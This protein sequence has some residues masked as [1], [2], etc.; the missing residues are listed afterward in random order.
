[1]SN[2]LNNLFVTANQEVATSSHSL[3]G[4]AQ[5]TN[6]ASGIAQQIMETVN[7]NIEEYTEDIS[8]SKVD[9]NAMDNLIEKAYELHDVDI[10]FLK[11]I[12]E[13]TLEGMLKSQQSKR[14]RCKSKAMTLDNYKALMT[15]AIAENLIRIATGKEK[16]AGIGRRV[17]GAVEYTIEQLEALEADQEKLRKEIRNI[18]SKK[19]IMKSKADFDENDERYQSLLKVEQQLKDMRVG[20]ST[21]VVEVDK[22]RETLAEMLA[23]VDLE[24]IKAAES[25]ELLESIVAIVFEEA[26]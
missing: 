12:D 24:H 21:H 2:E 19:S 17:A 1:M 22:V 10:D 6:V 20:A 26:E 16:N 5:L 8:K 7:N 11:E 23:E 25:K 4:T 15:G 9:N 13:A 3:S 14:S 18:Q